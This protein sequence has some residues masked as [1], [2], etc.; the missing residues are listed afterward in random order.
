MVAWSDVLISYG[1]LHVGKG[2]A[3]LLREVDR[4]AGRLASPVA[5]RPS[6]WIIVAGSVGFPL[7]SVF[8][9]IR[10]PYSDILMLIGGFLSTSLWDIAEEMMATVQVAGARMGQPTQQAAQG[11]QQPS[12]VIY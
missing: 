2:V 1:S 3:R 4:A 5:E 9:N 7:A 6:T 8:L 10:R 12:G 11:Q